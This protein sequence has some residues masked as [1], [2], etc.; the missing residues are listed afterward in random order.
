MTQ[1]KSRKIKDDDVCRHA[2]AEGTGTQEAGRHTDRQACRHSGGQAGRV[3]VRVSST[4]ASMTPSRSRTPGTELE[5]L[6]DAS[7]FTVFSSRIPRPA[8]DASRHER[9]PH[10]LDC[11]SGAQYAPL[12]ETSSEAFVVSLY[13]SG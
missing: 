1:K 11:F 4:R 5:P 8:G 7:A 3:R 9:V 10:V 13:D 12:L 6:H 2:A